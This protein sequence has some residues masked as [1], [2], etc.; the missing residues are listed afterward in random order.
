MLSLIL[1]DLGLRRY[2]RTI[3]TDP[4]TAG[5][6]VL[7]GH[8]Q[9]DVQENVISNVMKGASLLDV[10]GTIFY[11]THSAFVEYLCIIWFWV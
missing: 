9:G 6:A 10:G 5:P 1:C 2:T 11:Y 8:H 3:S 4:D 7:V